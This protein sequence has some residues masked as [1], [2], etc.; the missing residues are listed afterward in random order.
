MR[1]ALKK[2]GG[3][4]SAV[5]PMEIRNWDGISLEKS[6]SSY[7]AN[8]RASGTRKREILCKSRP[9]P[10]DTSHRLVASPV[11]V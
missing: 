11:Q 4:I 10:V 9:V 8:W 5:Q 7:R 1:V 3:R 2:C 6:G